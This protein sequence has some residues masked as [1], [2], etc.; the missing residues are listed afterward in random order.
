MTPV[1]VSRR[2]SCQGDSPLSGNC[3]SNG[4]SNAERVE[5][6]PRPKLDSFLVLA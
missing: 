6:C 2:F 1:H 3:S 5:M 4:V